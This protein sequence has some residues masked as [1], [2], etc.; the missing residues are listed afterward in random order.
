MMI[1]ISLTQ[2]EADYIEYLPWNY[3]DFPGGSVVK[4]LPAKEMW[5]QFL[6]WQDFLSPG[7]RNGNTLQYSCLQRNPVDRGTW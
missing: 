4:N 5:I 1:N 2:V 7:E 3:V 6:G